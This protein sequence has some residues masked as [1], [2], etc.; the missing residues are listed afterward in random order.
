MS[1]KEA[2]KVTEEIAHRQETL[3]R[4]SLSPTPARDVVAAER[5]KLAGVRGNACNGLP[6]LSNG[7]LSR[8]NNQ[9]RLLLLKDPKTLPGFRSLLRDSRTL[10]LPVA[11]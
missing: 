6:P 2:A 3:K 9:G 8:L 5:E 4:S 10:K 11:L 1:E 7:A